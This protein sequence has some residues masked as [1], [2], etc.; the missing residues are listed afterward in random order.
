MSITYGDLNYTQFPDSIDTYSYFSDPT[1]DDIQLIK[2]YQSYFNSGNISSAAQILIDNPTLQNKIINANNLNKFVDSIKAMQRLYMSDIQSYIMELV[3]YKGEYSTKFVY[4]KYDV[5]EYEKQVYMCTSLNCPMGTLPTNTNH[6]IK[7]TLKG[8]KGDS[9][10]GLAPRG[11]WDETI[12][13]YQDDLVSYN[14]ALWAAS[15]ENI[16]RVPS[17]ESNVWYPVLTLNTI[18]EN[19]K[20]TNSEID[21]IFNGTAVLKD[22]DILAPEEEAESITQ[23]EIDNVLNN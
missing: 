18:L 19:A 20:I 9:G 2:Q 14:N 17:K 3:T 7:L 13:Y 23:E 11:I 1:A 15:A 22:D 12:H 16:N 10:L 6:F 8:D 21:D 4:S 5:T